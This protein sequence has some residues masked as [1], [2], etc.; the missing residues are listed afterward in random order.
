MAQLNV[1]VALIS[2][3]SVAGLGTA[4]SLLQ[5]KEFCLP[6]VLKPYFSASLLLF[7]V[8]AFLGCF[9]VITRLLDFRLTARKVR[10]QT[11]PNYDKSLTFLWVGPDGYGRASWF[12]FWCSCFAFSVAVVLLAISF[13]GAYADRLF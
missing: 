1:A 6:V 12:L 11:T 5:N 4:V 3:L 10:K 2:G 8:A 13:C 7:F 9:V